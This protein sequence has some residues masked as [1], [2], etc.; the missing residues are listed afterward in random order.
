MRRRRGD[1]LRPFYLS[2]YVRGTCNMMALLIFAY[3]LTESDV[4]AGMLALAL[5]AGLVPA[6]GIRFGGGL[7]KALYAFSVTLFLGAFLLLL[8]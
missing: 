4:P 6:G 3:A 7:E 2:K 1:N 5:I 8:I